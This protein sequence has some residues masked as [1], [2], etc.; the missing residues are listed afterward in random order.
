MF[1]TFRATANGIT[2]CHCLTCLRFPDITFHL[3]LAWEGHSHARHHRWHSLHDRRWRSCSGA[4]RWRGWSWRW[5]LDHVHLGP[6]SGAPK[7]AQT[8]C[9]RSCRL[10][11]NWLKIIHDQLPKRVFSK[12][13]SL[14]VPPQLFPNSY[15]DD[16]RCPT[17]NVATVFVRSVLCVY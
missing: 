14:Q 4:S 17:K 13:R 10:G 15:L 3:R 2:C 12:Q 9:W 5:A 8:C 7:P 1:F 11:V 6:V 16:C